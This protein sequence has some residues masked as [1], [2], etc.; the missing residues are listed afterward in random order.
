MREIL[1]GYA[2]GAPCGVMDQMASALGRE[3]EL[4]VLLCRPATVCVLT[5]LI[6]YAGP[7]YSRCHHTIIHVII[8]RLQDASLSY[9]MQTPQPVF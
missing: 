3:G 2:V 9:K 5:L 7:V 4:L 1:K 6:T 8:S